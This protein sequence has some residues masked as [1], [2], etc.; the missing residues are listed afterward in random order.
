M[1]RPTFLL[2][3]DN[4]IFDHEAAK[5]SID[6][7]LVSNYGQ[8]ANVDLDKIYQ[9]VKDELGY[10]DWKQ[11][12]I[13]FAK[14]RNSE[15]YASVLAVFLEIPFNEYLRP[16]AQE[17]IEFLK[18]NGSLIIF[19]DGDQ[20]FQKT[21]IEKLGLS[22]LADEV[23][24]SKSKIDLFEELQKK[25]KGEIFVIDDKP[26]VIAK[27]KEVL[28]DCITIW[29]KFGRHTTSLATTRADFES[30]DLFKIEKFI[31]GQLK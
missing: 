1:N 9:E 19:S 25:Y 14:R 18:K 4:T 24:I 8:G 16:G 3:V 30:D 26:V 21:K 29:V 5:R 10:I 17:F 2:D 20:L 28:A 7:R 23:V 13:R 27:A 22:S 12:A 15:D 11:I 31:E 6:E